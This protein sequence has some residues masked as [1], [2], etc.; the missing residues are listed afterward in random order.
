MTPS[1]ESNVP[2]AKRRRLN[3]EKAAA[4]PEDTTT[5]SLKRPVS[6]PIT[7]RK[8]P[9]TAVFSAPTATWSFDDVPKQTLAPSPSIP[10]PPSKQTNQSDSR[11]IKVAKELTQ[12]HFK[13]EE[14]IIASPFQ[15]TKI[16]DLAPYQNVDTIELKDILGDPMIK[17]CWNFNFLF[18]LDFVM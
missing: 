10:P 16:R 4:K 9:V 1:S 7:R 5:T 6:P 17:E 14:K 8:A 12:E 15:L 3:D 13:S 2:P 18:D 11:T